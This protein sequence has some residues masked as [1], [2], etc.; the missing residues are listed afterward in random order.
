MTF[1]IFQCFIDA[2]VLNMTTLGN[3]ILHNI[4]QPFTRKLISRLIYMKYV[5]RGEKIESVKYHK[6]LGVWEFRIDGVSYLSFGPG[7]AY[8]YSHLLERLKTLSGHFY[9]PKSGD[10]VIDIGA[11]IGEETVILQSLVGGQGKVY[12]IEAHPK[13]FQTLQYLVEVNS[14][15]N[16]V[17][18]N[19]ALADEPGIVSIDDSDNSFA[20]SILSTPKAKSFQVK[21][22]TFDEFVRR[23]SIDQIDLV[24]MN[25]EGAE[26]LIIKGMKDS[27][28]AI[29]HMAISCH[30]FRHKGGESEFFKTKGVI[31]QFLR[32]HKFSVETQSTNNDMIDDY[33]Y[34]TN[35]VLK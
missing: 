27:I 28:S 10:V 17:C 3:R 7:W 12:A 35:P 13:T 26:Q 33:V 21:A 14:L 15:K 29:K 24:K 32:D 8:S 2:K 9:L 6:R 31:M 20:N 23:N 4:D 11:G 30:D 5:S 18:S 1:R 16:V 22:E 19:V 25:V 34:A